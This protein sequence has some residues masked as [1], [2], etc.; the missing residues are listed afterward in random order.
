MIG[1]EEWRDRGGQTRGVC[2]RRDS[3]SGWWAYPYLAMRKQLNLQPTKRCS[4]RTSTMEWPSRDDGGNTM[5]Q[6]VSLKG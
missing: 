2:E 5:V 6:S 1:V 4:Q 3:A